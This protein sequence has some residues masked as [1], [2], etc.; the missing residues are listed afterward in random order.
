M[1]FQSTCLK[2]TATAFLVTGLASGLAGCGREPVKEPKV[3]SVL[4]TLP[5]PTDARVLS[6]SGGE[7]A[8]QVVV[9]SE[10]SP[11]AIA[12]FYRY[13]FSHEPWQLVSDQKTPDGA[14]VLFAERSGPPMWVTIRKTVGGSGTTIEISG[15]VATD[16][17]RKSPP[18]PPK[19]VS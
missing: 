9:H 15:A 19:P 13:V 3:S 7:E 14:Q 18:Q 11:E 6:R 16:P 1:R 4:P 8:L 5:V 10:Q 12:G 2:V 17:T